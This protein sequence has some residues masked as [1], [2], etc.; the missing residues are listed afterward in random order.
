MIVNA[1]SISI[2]ME[3]AVTA[4]LWY[5]DLMRNK[6]GQFVKG[7]RASRATEFKKGEHW[8]SPQ[9]YWDKK[10]LVQEYVKN[11]RSAADIAL[12]FDCKENNILHFL[13]KHGICTRSMTDIRQVKHW[14]LSGEDNG[15]YGKYGEDSS[16]W[17]GGVTPERQAI[18]VSQEWKKAVS[19]VW[20]RDNATCQRCGIT[21]EDPAVVHHV[22]HI[23]SF[24]DS[25][26]L[27]IDS[28][29][30]VLLCH[31]CHSWVHSNVNTGQL[32]RKE[33]NCDR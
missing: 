9:P 21:R 15:M 32:F 14:G 23:V 13:K 2:P 20:R 5:N 29:N 8:R 17:K 33:V 3:V 28:D 4:V 1:N 16:N 12:Q 26:E 31:D 24:A 10:W 18:Y 6:K 11:Q 27:R 30:L 7:E 25:A 19:V 22:H